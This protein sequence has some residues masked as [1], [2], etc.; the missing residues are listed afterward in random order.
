MEEQLKELKQTMN[1]MISEEP[2]FTEEQRT[3][4]RQ[5]IAKRRKQSNRPFS[6]KWK[7]IASVAACLILIIFATQ[8]IMSESSRKPSSMESAGG[9]GNS[10]GDQNTALKDDSSNK[11]TLLEKHTDTDKSIGPKAE[12]NSQA[13]NETFALDQSAN[14]IDKKTF[15]GPMLPLN[16][17]L[18]NVYETFSES[19]DQGALADLNPFEVMQLYYHAS[20]QGEYGTQHDLFIQDVRYG[21]PSKQAYLDDTSKDSAI[22]NTIE[23]K[24]TRFSKIESFKQTIYHE[25]DPKWLDYALINW[26]KDNDITSFRLIKNKDGVWTVSWM[27]IQ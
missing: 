11:A 27:P 12:S 7:A 19:H 9:G 6:A 24:I 1:R 25:P 13:K 22:V 10:S 17:K 20:Q 15:E 26:G 4:I 3:K 18:L 2:K 14:V 8:F 16:D 21:T 23:R 5:T